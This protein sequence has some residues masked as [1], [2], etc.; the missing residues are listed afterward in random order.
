MIEVKNLTIGYTGNSPV[1]KDVN[2][3]TEPG[4]ILSIIGP[5]GSGKSSLIK[6]ILG[7]VQPLRGQINFLEK[8]SEPHTIGY[9]PQTPRFPTNIKVRELI[10]F[11]KK[12][13]PV[14]EDRF[15]NL[16]SILELNNHMDKKIGS[17]SGGTKQKISILQCFS[18]KK[19]LYIIDEPTASLDPYISH[20]LKSLLVEKKK[21]GSL[22]IFSTHILAELQ[23]LAD[24]FLLLSEGSILIDESPENFLRKNNKSNLDQ[25][26]MNFWNEEYKTKQ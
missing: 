10:S 25:A 12:L 21:E 23:E 2:F 19:D 7:L 4:T 20:L 18:S 3:S 26:L 6:G 5:N 17:L 8:K 22:V 13:E 11:F 9:M 24:R 1:V 16:I 15:Q 14:E